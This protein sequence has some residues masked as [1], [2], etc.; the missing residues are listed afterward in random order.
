MR[1]IIAV[2]GILIIGFISWKGYEYYRSTYVGEDYYA[3]VTAPLPEEQD[4]LSQ[5]GEV[6]GRG[7]EYHLQAFNTAGK[8]RQITISITTSGDYKNGSALPEG[9]VLR[10]NASKNRVIEQ[11]QISIDDVPAAIQSKLQ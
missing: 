4:I 3:V 11:Q 8:E 5:S 10:I 7:Y 1:K 2:V 9:T 6:M